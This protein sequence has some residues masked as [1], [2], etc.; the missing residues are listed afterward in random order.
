MEYTP[1][2]ALEAIEARRNGEWDNKELLKLGPLR[3]DALS[4]FQRISELTI[5]PDSECPQC[6]NTNVNDDFVYVCAC[7]GRETCPDCAGKCGCDIED[8]I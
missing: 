8:D 3:I 6:H 2:Q 1:E 4:D 7:C 5:H